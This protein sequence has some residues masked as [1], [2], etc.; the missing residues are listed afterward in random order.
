M[1]LIE[2]VHID[3]LPQSIKEFVALRGQVAQTPQGG[4]TMMIVALLLYAEDEALGQQCLTV[5]VDRGRLV[6]GTEGYK[7]WQLRTSDVRLIGS[8]IGKQSYLLQSYVKGATP[9]NGY[10]LPA[11]PYVFEFS[12]NPY[13]GDPDSGT[14]K[15]FV[16]CSGASRPRPVTV[17]RNDRGIWK[18]HEWSS[19]LVGV[20]GP[21]QKSQDDL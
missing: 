10:Q 16:S 3:R 19:I 4:A 7:G 5:A 18:A 11:L 1:T 20:Q 9:E 12:D 14:Y 17:K 2:P 21:V 13:S 6:E 15:V 8:Q